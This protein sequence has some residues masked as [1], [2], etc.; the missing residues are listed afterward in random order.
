MNQGRVFGKRGR[1]M[2]TRH[3]VKTYSFSFD[4]DV[5]HDRQQHWNAPSLPPYRSPKRIPLSGFE[6]RSIASLAAASAGESRGA[7]ARFGAIGPTLVPGPLSG[8]RQEGQAT[9]GAMMAEGLGIQP[10][11]AGRRGPGSLIRAWLQGW[12]S[13]KSAGGAGRKFLEARTES[14]SAAKLMGVGGAVCGWQRRQAL[15]N[16][17]S[18]RLKQQKS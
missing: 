6:L 15:G 17:A 18:G 11:S 13:R 7:A 2:T 16:M 1:Q 4:L 10:Q 9:E 8:Q 5:V 3:V 14:R 12:Q